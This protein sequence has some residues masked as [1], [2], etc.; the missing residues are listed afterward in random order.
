MGK[1]SDGFLYKAPDTREQHLD[2]TRK[3]N[4]N[5][6]WSENDY[7]SRKNAARNEKF[8]VLPYELD[9]S[10]TDLFNRRDDD[11]IKRFNGV[12]Y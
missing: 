8:N 4:E 6:L 7:L 1:R 3:D 12:G 2:W 11:N 5:K 10:P 9:W